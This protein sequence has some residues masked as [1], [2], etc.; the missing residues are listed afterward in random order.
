MILSRRDTGK[1]RGGRVR[2]FRAFAFLLPA[3][4]LALLPT[5]AGAAIVHQATITGD[6]GGSPGT[7]VLVNNVTPGP[8]QLYLVSVA[9]YGTGDDVAS[10]SGGGLTWTLQKAQ[11]SARLSQPKVEIWQAFGSPSSTFTVTVTLDGTADVIS[12]AVSRYS[13]VDSTTPTEGAAGSNTHG[14][15]GICDGNGTDNTAASLSLTSS[16]NNSVLYVATHPRNNKIDDSPVGDD[17]DYTE[18]AHITNS[19][20]SEGANL[21]VHDRTLAIAGTDSA[22]HTLASSKDWDMAGVVINPASV[23]ATA[24]VTSAVGEISPNDVDMGSTGNSFSYDIQATISGSATGVNKVEIPVPASFGAPTVV[25]VDVNG[26]PVGYNDATSGNTI[27]V[28]LNT[29]VT[30]SSTITV[31]FNSDAPGTQDLL[32]VGF[33]ATIDD[34]GTGEAAQYV[35]EGNG[36]GDAGDNNSWSVTTTNNN[37]AVTSAV[38]EIS[39]NDVSMSTSANAFSYDIQTTISGAATGVDRVTI[40]LPSGF[41]SP[42]VTAVQVNGS[43]VTFTDNTAGTTVSVDLSSKVTTSGKITVLFTANAP[44]TEDLVGVNFTSTVDDSSTGAAAQSTTQGNGDGDPGDNDSWTVTTTDNALAVTSAV[45]EISPADVGTNT[46]YYAFDYDIAITVGAGETGVDRVAITVPASF[47]A[48]TIKRVRVNGTNV[49]YTNNTSGNNIS[50]DLNARVSTSSTITVQ[51]ISDPPA[52]QDLTGVNFTSTVDEST[53]SAAAV[54]TTEGNGDGDAGDDNTW[55]V[56]TTDVPAGSCPAVDGVASTGSAD[57]TNSITISHTTSGT[58]R[59]MLVG[60]SINNEDFETVSSVT[61]NGVALTHVGSATEADDAV[62]EIWR[63]VNPPTGTHNV[64]ITFSAVLT[65]EAVAGVMTFTGVDQTTPL[66]TFASAIDND[67]GPAS[68]IVSSAAGEL[69]FGVVSAESSVLSTAAVAPSSQRWNLFQG[70]QYGAGATQAGAAS[71]TMSWTFNGSDHWAAGGVSIKPSGSCNPAVTSAVAEISPNNVTTSSTGNSFSYDI[72]ANISGAATGVNRVE[73]TVPGTF[74]VPTVT[75]VQVDG[76]SVAYTNNSSGNT[77]S[78]DLTTK[79][80]AS[81]K[82]TVLF[83]ADAPTTQDLTGVDFTSTV[84]DTG[85]GDVAQAT[86]EGDGDGEPGDSNSW[87]VTTTDGAGGGGG[88]GACPAPGAG[89]WYPGG[90]L[91]RKPLS[92]GAGNVGSNLTD[93]PVLVSLASDTDLAADAQAD[94][95]DILFTAADGT[96]KLS[97]EIEKYNETTGELV[98]WVKVPTV[99]SS[100]DTVFYMY[101]GNASA[102][103]QQDP[104]GVWSNGYAGVW[105]LKEDPSGTAPQMNDSTSNTIHGTSVGSMTS[106][107]QIGGKIAGALDFDGSDDYLQSSDYDILSTIT[108]SAWVN[109]DAISANNEGIVSKRTSDENNGNWALRFNSGLYEWMV[110]D[111]IDSSDKLYSLSAPTAGQWEYVVLTFDDPSNTAKIYIDGGLDNSTTSM[112]KNL[113]DT[114]EIIKIAQ[115]G[116]GSTTLNG[117]LDEVRLSSAVRSADWIT[118]EYINQADHDNFQSLCAEETDSSTPAVTSAVAEIS[119]NDVATNSTGNSF[120][121]D[122][123][124]TIGGGDT[125]VNRVTIT[126]PG[127][128]GAPTVSDVQDDGVSVGYTNN[129]VGNAISVDITTKITASS[130][131]TVLFDSDAPTTQDLTGVNFTSTVDDSGT[132]DAAQATTEGNGDGD[133]GDLNSWTVTTTDSTG[134]LA[135]YWLDEAASGQVPANLTDSEA[136]PLNLAITYVATSPEWQD[137]TGGNRHLRFYGTGSTTDTGGAQANSGA[138]KMDGLHGSQTA[139]LVAKYAMDSN[140]CTNN[141]DRIVGISDGD[142]SAD[143]W[144]AMRERGSRDGLQVRWAGVGTVGF[145]ALGNGTPSCPVDSASTVHWV[146]DTTQATAAD[147]VKAYIDGVAQTVQVMNGA[148]PPQNATIDLGPGTRKM[149][150]G[151]PHTGYRTFRGRIWY[152]A[153]YD[154]ALSSATVSSDASAINACDDAACEPAVTSAVAEITPNDVVTSST[155]NSFTYDIQATISGS[156]TGVNRVTITVPGTFGAPTVTGV[157]VGGVGVAYT[158]NTSGNNI[159]IDLTTKVTTS[160][161]ITV[162]FNADAPT[163]QDLVGVDFLSTVDDTGTAVVSQ[164]TTEGNGDGDAGDNNSWAVTTTNGGSGNLIGHWAFNDGSGQTATDSSASSNN[165]TLGTSAGADSA[166]PAWVCSGT[167]LDFDGSND[168]VQLG[169]VTVG[170]SAAWTISA[171]IKMSA[172]TADQRTIYSEGNTGAEEYL[173]LYVDD[174]P[175]TVRFYSVESGGSNYA[176][177][178]GTSNVEDDT[179]HLV[180]LVQRSKTD[181]ELYVDGISEATN[182]QNAGTYAF[183]T[184]SIGFLR[185]SSWTADPFLG[186][187]DDVR[188]YDYALTTGEIASLAAAPPSCGANLAVTSAV[189]EISP[190]DVITS[191]TGN[192]FSYDIQASIGGGDTGVNRVAI[193]VPGTFGAPTVTDVLDDGVSVPYTDNTAGNA[194]SV[195]LTTKITATSKITVVFTSNAP[196]TQDLT[197]VNFTSTVDDSGT[198]DAAQSTT[199]GNGDGDSGDNNSWTVTTTDGACPAVSTIF[200]DNFE[201]GNLNLWD[202]V[203]TGTGDSIASSTLQANSGIYS[204]RAE[205]DNVST[206]RARVIKNFAGKTTVSGRAFIYLDPTWS[207]TAQVELLY[208]IA[209]GQVLTVEVQDDM[210]LD[211]WNNVASESYPTTATMTKGTWHSLE[212]QAVI[213]GASSEARLWLD[214]TLIMEQTGINLGSDPITQFNAGYHWAQVQTEANILYLDDAVLCDVPI[215]AT[216]S[217]VTSAVAEITP[218]DVETSSTGNAFTYDIQATIGAGDTGVNRVAITVPAGFSTVSVTGV[219]VGGVGVAY[220]DNTVGNAIS[221]DLNTK[222]TSSSK[223]TVLFTADAPTSQD[224]IGVDF[225][226]TVDD[227]VTGAA[228]QATTEGNGDGDAGDNNSW[229]VTTTNAAVAAGTA[230]AEI[231]PNDVATN[232]TANAFSYDIAVTIGGS[233]TGVNRVAITVPGSFGAP[234]VTAVQVDGVGVAYTNNTVGNNI[235]VDLTTKV[236][237]SS[238]I[239]VLFTSDAPTTQDLVGVNF[240]STVDDSG[241]GASAQSTTQGNGDGNA[242]DNNSWVVTTTDTG[243]FSCPI[244]S[245]LFSDG[246]ESGDFSAWDGN[247]TGTAGDSITV[248]TEQAKTGTYSAKGVSDTTYPA[249]AIVWKTVTGQTTIHAKAEIYLPTGFSGGSDLVALRFGN[250]WTNIVTATVNNDRTM[251]IW[252]DVV[253][254]G[255]GVGTTP[256]LSLDTWHTIELRT[257]ISDTAGEARLWID[258]TLEITATGKN[259]GTSNADRLDTPFYWGTP[260]TSADTIY[261]DDAVICGTPTPAVTSAV[262]EISPNDVT[263]SSTGNSFSYDIQ[264][265]IGG[266]DTGVDRVAITVPGNFGAPTITGVQVDGVGVA[267]TNNTVGN[268]ISVDLTTKVTASSKITILFDADGPTT[269]NLTGDNFLST[270]D[271]SGTADAAQNT[272]EGNGD[273]DAGDNNSWTVTTTDAAGG[274]CAAFDASSTVQIP[275]TSPNPVTFSHTTSGSDRLLLVSVASQPNADDAVFEAV[276][277]ITYG[278]QALT[279][280]GT[281]AQ[282][283]DNARIEIWQLVNPP[284][285]SNTVSITFNDAFDDPVNGEGASAGAISFTGVHQTTPLG[286]FASAIANGTVA[287]TPS[288]N[289]SSATGELVFDTVARKANPLTVDASQTER[290]H[291]CTDNGCSNIDGA[292]STE[293][294]AASVTMS[295]SPDNTRWALGAVPIKPS[296][297]CNS[298]VTS[299]VAEI[300]PNDVTTSS[301]GNAFSY[302]ITATIAGGDSGVNLV[303]ITVPGSFGVPTVTD[304][305]VDDLSVPYTDNTSGN[306]IS[307]V[308][309]SKLTTTGKITVLFSADAPTTQDLTGVDFVSTVDD[310]GTSDT[311]QATTEGNGDGN[312][313]DNNSWTVTTTD[314]GGGGP[315]NPVVNSTGDAGDAN[316]GNGVCDTGGLNSQSNAECTLRAAIQEANATAGLD[317]IIFNMPTSEPGY[318][319]APL[320]YTINPGSALPTIS[321]QVVIDGTTQTGYPGTPI[322]V[323]DGNNVAASGL[324]LGGT[325]DTSTIRGLVIRDFGTNGIQIEAGSDSHTIA[326]NYIGRLNASG[327]D[328]GV[329]EDNASRGIEVLG[330]SSTIGGTVAAD[331]NVIS[332]NGGEGIIIRSGASSNIVRGNYIGTAADGTTA[333]GNGQEGIQID[334]GSPGTIIGGSAAG[335]GNVIGAN[336]ISSGAAVSIGGDG[337]DNTVVQGNYIGTDAGGTLDLGNI[338]SGVEVRGTGSAATSPLNTLIG[339]TAAGEGNVIRYNDLD[340]VRIRDVAVDVAILGNQID[341]SSQQGIDLWAAG[342]NDNVTAND[343]GDGDSGANHL[344]NYPVIT[345][346]IWNAGNVDVNFDLDVPAGNYRVEFFKNPSGADPSGN[347]EGET[348][349]SSVNIAHGGSGSESFAHSFSGAISDILSATATEEI[350]GPA[351]RNT[352]EFSATY[353][354]TAGAAVAAAVAEISPNDVTTSGGT[355]LFEYDIAATIGAANTGVDRVAITVPASFGVSSLPVMNVLIDGVSV[356]FT[357][358]SVGNAIS[359]DLTTK[360]T[361]NARITVLFEANAPSTEDLT[362]VDFTSTVDDSATGDAAQAATEGEGDGDTEDNNSWTVTTTG[363]GGGGGGSCLVIDGTA[364]TGS[365]ETA[366]MTISHTT[367]GTDRLMLVGVSINNNNDEEVVSPSGITYNGVALTRVGFV[368]HQGSG[369]NDGRVE[370]WRLL[371]PATGTHNVVVNFTADL[372]QPAIAGVM[373][374]TGVDQ[375]TPLGAFA[376]NYGT[377]NAA[378]VSVTSAVD[379][380]VF[381]VMSGETVTSVA[382]DAPAAEQ[383]NLSV[384]GSLITHYG[385]GATE[386]GAATTTV[387]WSLGSSDYWAAAGV[388]IKGQTG[389]GTVPRATHSPTISS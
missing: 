193:T 205:V 75:G 328:A 292:A 379:E 110:W 179:W 385:A 18:R 331:R 157:Q 249:Q 114:P 305:L 368:I 325:G 115:H 324:T 93:F 344:M 12:A 388:S 226:S 281:A 262:A 67:S 244:G 129:T 267:Y 274:A 16:N 31:L 389:C 296:G 258:G 154:T 289:V 89:G 222:V 387:D 64:V 361:T 9:I 216:G 339:G 228:A 295:W 182:T 337:S 278:G 15:N 386:D 214:D 195:D 259:L 247:T 264:A 273:G 351:F 313:G 36:D 354:V 217:A 263:T 357:D 58:D 164:S 158:D 282:G 341:S 79:V 128:F 2:R 219:Q 239:T 27:S 101:Y 329:G 243:G 223:L 218:N 235:S 319:G 255:Y 197:G 187:I 122:I 211:L 84:D 38:A 4:L 141:G 111:G 316:A 137:G 178:S 306:A 60:V 175:N 13:G 252:N 144:L 184:S 81:S 231:S 133:A 21:H 143:G 136:S 382:T 352:S 194:I 308:L 142:G 210:T 62:V 22:D 109:W 42:A 360:V 199:E 285:G 99:S 55:K 201:G 146:I 340:G 135:R 191:S 286:T 124:A 105:H 378:S 318:S 32:G 85:T 242:G 19:D 147:R 106:G 66:G 150:V 96:T 29:K 3:F 10:V 48:P 168:E 41:S 166:D 92:I 250:G 369:G 78:V 17:P 49:G 171:W 63:L 45:A 57:G 46:G 149:F 65:R 202:T 104:T 56:T 100:A 276:T 173:F 272:T 320:S 200:S 119:P 221:V 35:D 270:V 203:S 28:D 380:T 130:K 11:C 186:T 112:T 1:V 156:E 8:N 134:L 359:V 236:T 174:G 384:V 362:G 366:S 383:W 169:A 232:S 51:F 277:G 44:T 254:E 162:L 185:A 198:G 314:G 14:Q 377:S 346:A 287:D 317:T 73:I 279:V 34:S 47:G 268:A 353:T 260:G 120:S 196:T 6:T 70:I 40:P 321:D 118:A 288:V 82:I 102:T 161:K 248:S 315:A 215:G 204:A 253:S 20:S 125:G 371:A 349:L 230:V 116:Q 71:V 88:G 151:Q 381:A 59:L 121:Y 336:G 275:S 77:I 293:A 145:Y 30:A 95:D 229:T 33:F 26:S 370:I 310:N 358:N 234:T 53:T 265:T 94:F 61:Y 335:A 241:T 220:T 80:T 271:D 283:P 302:D 307:V 304:V 167:A 90:W 347:G 7:Q 323:L 39:P 334:T 327:T 365:T 355:Y 375:T 342:S 25:S 139:T 326:G 338:R 207:T 330:S 192:A 181:R 224:L 117:K 152:A 24:A 177:F 98:A 113:A 291:Q 163:T 69:V 132:G 5:F 72:Q 269:E 160:N 303:S 123:Q 373:T 43:G 312:A 251:F 91:Y 183:N 138:T 332:G 127:T 256:A 189:A 261:V 364:S 240:T 172:D 87:T 140:V 299:A 54:S 225:T 227:S 97:H 297:N 298:A 372:N 148:L 345:S 76:G 284:T 83:N 68:V 238:K 86:T 233:D 176:L 131:I 348:Y 363:A 212:I 376:S 108:V 290:W 206:A 311:P 237:A 165:G 37:P 350:S 159:S 333:L 300:S 208:L 50:V 309:T 126:V 266:G 155:G 107:N 245:S 213:N 188:I 74:G 343:A 190:N 180:T 209:T 322:V 257:T 170:N 153:I 23:S 374:F 280:V 301:T 52:T 356:T 367:S 246:F 294:G 103:N